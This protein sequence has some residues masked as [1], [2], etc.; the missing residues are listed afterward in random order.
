[1]NIKRFVHGSCVANSYVVT[2][3]NSNKAILIDCCGANKKILDYISDSGC[4]LEAILLTH[5]HFDHIE[6]LR[7]LK[8]KTGAKI[9]IFESEK[10]F[11]F[12]NSLNLSNS[13]GDDSFVN[14]DIM[15]SDGEMIE[16]DDIKIQV[17]HTPGHTSGSVCYLIEN[18]LFTGDTL[19]RLT[20]GRTDFPTG[21]YSKLIESINNK[22]FLLD[23]G[24]KVYPGHG[25]STSIAREKEEN[26]FL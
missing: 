15:L 13:T 3:E 9:Y 11:L 20:I 23:G 21:D 8:D 10:A 17:I 19:F 7:E 25:L 2:T 1:M 14:A 6:G 24:I 16:V 12:D 26:P 4:T 18:A 5:G 22:L